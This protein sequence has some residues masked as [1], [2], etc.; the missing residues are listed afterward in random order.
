MTHCSWYVGPNW[1]CRSNNA[2]FQSK[3]TRS[4]LAVTPRKKVQL[5]LIALLANEPKMNIIRCPYIKP[6]QK[7]KTAVFR[8]KLHFTWRKSATKFLSANAL[9]DKVVRHSLAY[10]SVQ[11]WFAGGRPLLCE[12]LAESDQPL[13][14]ADFQS[15]FARNAS[16]V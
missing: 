6:P 12:N 9:S 1:H 10:L 16:A 7:R 15:I 13:K 4:T 5:T 11:K 8:L 2:D 3:Y 14:N